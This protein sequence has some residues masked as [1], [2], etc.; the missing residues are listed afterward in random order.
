MI[1]SASGA[2]QCR[3]LLWLHPLALPTRDG[4]VRIYLFE[5]ANVLLTEVYVLDVEGL[6]MRLAK[7]LTQK[8]THVRV[9]GG[10]SGW[11][12]A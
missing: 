10:R 11:R 4:L 9:C 3:R 5:V 2:I 8:P 7:S 6:G 12:P 1:L